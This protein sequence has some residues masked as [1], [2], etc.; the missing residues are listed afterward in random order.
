[1]PHIQPPGETFHVI[2]RLAG[3]L[4]EETVCSL[5]RWL[6]EEEA[7]VRRRY[8]G[9]DDLMD[10]IWA[11]RRAHFVQ[12][13]SALDASVDSPRWLVDDVIA[14][15]VAEAIWYRAR[16]E[17]VLQTYVIMPNHVHIIFSPVCRRDSSTY[18]V[19]GI[20]ENLK[21]YTALTCN[22]ILGRTGAFWH[23]ESY[24]HIIRNSDELQWT[25]R[26]VLDNPVRA[27]L[28]HHPDEWTWR[29]PRAHHSPGHG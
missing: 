9:S 12:F 13:E 23:H 10:R 6:K 2:F 24:D 15:V 26:F 3:S 14:G 29:W 27:G 17:Y 22:R 28:T 18:V 20:L 5:H 19:T 16:A 21:W 8:G 4:A 25:S 1:M 11:V 7:R